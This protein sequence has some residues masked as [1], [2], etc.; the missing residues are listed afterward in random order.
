MK[1]TR[2][3]FLSQTVVGAMGAGMALTAVPNHLAAQVGRS[4]QQAKHGILLDGVMA[5]W[6]A[7]V[8]SNHILGGSS[9]GGN[10]LQKTSTGG[11]YEEIVV[12]CG[13]GMS[14]AFYDWLKSATQKQSLRKS[15]AIVACDY[16]E[17][18]RSRIEFTNATISEIGFPALDGASKDP[19]MITIKFS[20]EST[21]FITKPA[22]K[23]SA[24][25]N[26]KQKNWLA[27]NFRLQ[28]APMDCAYV[29]K[30]DAITI[31]P[32]AGST[33]IGGFGINT[34]PAAAT[35]VPALGITMAAAKADSLNQWYA[36]C[37][38]GKIGASTKRAGQL[39]YLAPDLQEALF[40]LKFGNLGISSLSLSTGAAEDMEQARLSWDSVDFSYGAL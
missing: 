24:P 9:G 18:E 2:R 40:T 33:P 20:P 28:I 1:A 8:E 31:R 14:K 22:G 30:I 13:T 21:H 16:N 7:A 17:T 29:S 19:A 37:A 6:L 25:L 32:N 5:G 39:D 3:E 12:H 36:E 27:S 10:P 4:Y 26:P 15:G 23:L 38:L 34:K 35:D 11:R